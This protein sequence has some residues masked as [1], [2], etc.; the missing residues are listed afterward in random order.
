MSNVTNTNVFAES[1]KFVD[2]DG[3]SYFWSKTKS[4]VDD[5]DTRLSGLIS[6]NTDAIDAINAELE[7]LSGGAGSIQTQIDNAIA[8]LD[9]PNT[10]EAKGEA[11]KAETA[12]KL[13]A[14]GLAV[15][16]DVAGS[17][18]DVASDLYAHETNYVAHI[19]ANERTSWNSAKTAIDAFLADA[20][21]TENA[22]DTLA[23]LQSYMTSDGA[24]AT[25]LINRVA[26]LEGIDH[27]A[28]I[29]A[30]ETNL[31]AAK[32]Y[33]DDVINELDPHMTFEGK[34]AAA[35]A[36]TEAKSYT[37]EKDS[38]MNTR[39]AK[40]EAVDHTVYAKAADVYTK[41]DADAAILAAKNAAIADADTKLKNYY[42]K[43]EVD[44]L[45]STNSQADQA[46]AKTY[47]DQLF[48]SFNFAANSDIDA[49][50]A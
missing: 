43:T 15:N 42:N 49:L 40:L 12:A 6:D 31:A 27:E 37:D 18:E 41:T 1:K 21:M 10:Y 46:Y 48:E 2:V 33:T 19:T 5:A 47:T 23:E 34:G 14:D 25:E 30:D 4:Y 36:L 22:V 35:E 11:A 13:Y 24:A 7:S 44:N 26:A 8:D 3:L 39:V 29:A 45:L 20:D 17:A 28:Y 16:Y 50:F 9:L 38:A 32:K